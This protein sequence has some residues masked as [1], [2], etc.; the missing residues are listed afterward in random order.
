[1]AAIRAHEIHQATT[2]LATGHEVVAVEQLSAKYMARRGGRRNAVSTVP[3]VTPPS[4]AS[5]S[6]STTNPPGTAPRW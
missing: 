1:M 2:G 3:L 6:S 4:G 5:A